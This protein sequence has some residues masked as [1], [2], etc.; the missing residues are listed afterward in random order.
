MRFLSGPAEPSSR[1]TIPLEAFL[2]EKLNSIPMEDCAFATRGQHFNSTI[3]MCC[4][5]SEKCEFVGSGKV[6]RSTIGVERKEEVIDLGYGNTTV[7]G[8]KTSDALKGNSPRLKEIKKRRN[9]RGI[10]NKCFPV[11]N[12]D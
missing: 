12:Q 7:P 9:S 3:G 5:S 1:D 4:N 2:G 10:F 11:P 6:L 8:D